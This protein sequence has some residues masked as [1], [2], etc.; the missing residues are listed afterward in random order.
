MWLRKVTILLLLVLGS[1][2][3]TVQQDP[4]SNGPTTITNTDPDAVYRVP[5][6]S[7]LPFVFGRSANGRQLYLLDGTGLYRIAAGSQAQL[8]IDKTLISSLPKRYEEALTLQLLDIKLGGTEH[9]LFVVTT[10]QWHNVFLAHRNPPTEGTSAQ[11]IQ[12]IK[13]TGSSSKARLLECNGSIYLVTIVTNV[14]TGKIRVYRWQQSYFSLESTKE[15]LSIDDVR[16]HCPSTLLLLVL[17]YAPLPERSLNHVLLLDSAERPVKVQ[18]MFFLHSTLPSFTLDGELYLIRHVSRDKSYL[19]Q[20]SAE[21]RFVRLRKLPN[22][23]EQITSITHWGS[24]LAVAFDGTVRLYGSSKEDLLRVESTFALRG[25]NTSEALTRLTVGAPGSGKLRRLYGLRAKS[26]TE[27]T[28]ATEFYCPPAGE[29]GSSTAL[30]IHQL[31]ILSVARSAE[32]SAQEHGFQTLN[33][34]LHRLKLESNERKKWIDLIRLQ[35]SRKNLLLDSVSQP[36]GTMALHPTVQLG[37][38]T[39]AH[40][41]PNLLPPSR[42]VLNG[43]SLLLR[44][45]RV[46]T[47]L[48]R[49]LLLNRARTEI[50]GDLHVAGDVRTRCSKIR[51]VNAL[52]ELRKGHRQRRSIVRVMTRTPYRV[53]RAREVITDSTLSKRFLLRS[54]MNVLP[55]TVQ[56]NELTTTTVRLEQGRINHLPVPTRRMLEDS[57]KHGY[58][59]HKVF[60]SIR[61]F[62]LQTHHLNG[63]PLAMPI[64][65]SGLEYANHGITI[66][67]DLCRTRNLLVRDTFNGLPVRRFA[68]QLQRTLHVKGNVRLAGPVCVK[69][70]QYDYTLND[71]PKGGLLDR[72]TNQTITGSVFVSK[73][74]THNLQVSRINGELLENYASISQ[75]TRQAVTIQAPVRASKMIILGDLRANHEE[76]QFA[77]YIGTKPG[78]LRQLYTGR[79]VLNG[80]LRLKVAN[81]NVPNITL[82]GQTVA[83]KLYQRFLL[84]TERQVLH[85]PVVYHAA[86]FQY[87][88]ANALGGVAL[89]QFSL[90]GRNWQNDIYLQDG[91]VRGHIRPARISKRLHSMQQDRVDVAAHVRVCDVKCVFTGRLQ[92][93]HLHTRTFGGRLDPDVLW[94]KDTHLGPARMAPALLLGRTEL[95]HSVLR[96]SQGALQ[97]GSINGHSSH[98]LAEMAKPPRRRYRTLAL[99]NLRASSVNIRQSANLA[100]GK[101]LQRFAAST[102]HQDHGKVPSYAR[103]VSPERTQHIPVAS[104]GSVNFCPVQRLLQD[105]VLKASPTPSRPI[106]GYKRVQGAVRVSRQLATARI[107]GHDAGL[108]ERIVTRGS[109]T[110]PQSV[111]ARWY[112]GMASSSFLTAKL[113]NGAPVARL[114]LHSD[115]PLALQ[116]ELLIDRLEVAS[117]GLPERPSWLFDPQAAAPV[118]L[119]QSIS[120]LRCLGTLHGGKYRDPVHPL[121]ELLL[122]PSLEQTRTVTSG[123]LFGTSAIHLGNCSTVGGPTEIER[124][125]RNCLRRDVNAA[126][127]SV[128]VF[129]QDTRFLGDAVP[130]AGHLH[131][132]DT[133]RLVA[134]TIAGVPVLQRLGPQAD[135]FLL[136]RSGTVRNE[137]IRGVKRF[138]GGLATV[139][140]MTLVS[141]GESSF[142]DQLTFC[143]DPNHPC[144]VSLIFGQPVTV[145][146]SLTASQLN[147]VPLDGFFHAFAKRRSVPAQPASLRPIQDFP[148]ML[149]VSALQLTGTGTILHH[150]NG[151]PLEELVLGATTNASHQAVP[152]AKI[153]RALHI[154]GPL[155][156]Q[157]LNTRPL[158]QVKRASLEPMANPSQLEAVIFNRPVTLT[159]LHTR[160]LYHSPTASSRLATPATVAFPVIHPQRP[161]VAQGRTSD[162]RAMAR[163]GRRPPTN[164]AKLPPTN[165]VT[166][167]GGETIRLHCPSDHRALVVEVR[168]LPPNRITE[169]RLHELPKTTGCLRIA[170]LLAFNRTTLAFL[171]WNA[172]PF[173]RPEES[174]PY[175]YDVGRGHLSAVGMPTSRDTTCRHVALLRP[176]PDELMMAT[177]GCAAGGVRIFRFETRLRLRHFQTIDFT[178]PVSAM[179][180]TDDATILQLQ[181][182]ASHRHRYAYSSVT[183]WTR[184]DEQMGVRP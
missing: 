114:A 152:G 19:Y 101:L 143:A 63:Q 62:R 59:G 139:R 182:A 183:G 36:A 23:Q 85:Q 131:V 47:D 129:R 166:L 73:G 38:V 82:M 66:K 37:S 144:A 9:V 10:D 122:A 83:S 92:V 39:L 52:E 132:A 6:G 40:E 148:G 81:V 57:A 153:F 165:E 102:Q 160:T 140:N 53:L 25:L 84:R 61:T 32:E 150:I 50:Q 172:D 34:C 147:H 158:A 178:A 15:V 35:L 184:E 127:R 69:H 75:G 110:A 68:N 87:L 27:L 8:D 33:G 142:W 176:A 56:L 134:Y 80:T 100:L 90:T 146:T 16:C 86:Q 163:R 104:V 88:F 91:T 162:A 170:G 125:A 168:A 108:L 1:G 64:I 42:T 41:E 105:T 138:P 157:Q 123:V 4:G 119:P 174:T 44:H 26:G 135:L 173:G 120:R 141:S 70:L 137:P 72:I 130:F 11:P 79:L 14:S 126:L 49:V 111:D 133:G 31:S 149:T 177:A 124:V 169:R 179:I 20:W 7:T 2:A 128:T 55:G 97:A 21:S 95:H 76:Q 71:V 106:T 180:P 78:D 103:I 58:R 113:L 98:E 136:P 65:E 30:L 156:L 99:A 89:W 17:D 116:G 117:I 154:D 181:D 112:F 164:E 115:R 151:L 155:A 167:P 54:R 93:T 48:N 118:R 60:R 51:A 161:A 5:C 24:T 94:R 29:P 3:V 96:M 109:E 67:T 121:H 175:L 107:D 18:E 45:H 46:A 22:N 43:Q 28:L 13:Y 145:A 159:A 74:F 12:R 171:L 77:P